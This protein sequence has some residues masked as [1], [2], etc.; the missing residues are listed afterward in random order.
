[1]LHLKIR[2]PNSPEWDVRR[3][4]GS[5]KLEDFLLHV[6]EGNPHGW[7]V[8]LVEIDVPIWKDLDWGSVF[9]GFATG[10]MIATAVMGLMTGLL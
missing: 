9:I 1:M 5:A 2:S 7:E 6:A 4:D 3:V 8:K 10:A